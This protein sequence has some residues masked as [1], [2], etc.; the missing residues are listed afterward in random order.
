LKDLAYALE[1]AQQAGV[2]LPGARRARAILQRAKD[3]GYGDKY[4]PVLV[5]TY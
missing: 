2:D 4:F 3:A 5:K 1:F